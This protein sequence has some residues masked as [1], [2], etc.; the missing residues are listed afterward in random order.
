MSQDMIFDDS[1]CAC[2][3]LDQDINKKEKGNAI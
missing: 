3:A 1:I 2:L